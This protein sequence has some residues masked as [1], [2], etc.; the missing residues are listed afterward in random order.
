M[1]LEQYRYIAGSLKNGPER[2]SVI[3]DYAAVMMQIGKSGLTRFQGSKAAQAQGL[4]GLLRFHSG[5]LG[6]IELAVDVV[7]LRNS[8]VERQFSKNEYIIYWN[9]QLMEFPFLKLD[10]PPK[11]DKVEMFT[12][13]QWRQMIALANK[14]LTLASFFEKENRHLLPQELCSLATSGMTER[15]L[16]GVLPSYKEAMGELVAGAQQ[17]GKYELMRRK[18]VLDHYDQIRARLDHE[19]HGVLDPQFGDLK[20]RGIQDSRSML[21]D[22]LTALHKNL[23]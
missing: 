4:E 21:L 19:I 9:A 8:L 2:I 1:S 22:T 12:N 5:D 23:S 13:E 16:M 7:M 18:G 6:A 10:G 20:T 3:D 11:E 15:L 14:D 17:P